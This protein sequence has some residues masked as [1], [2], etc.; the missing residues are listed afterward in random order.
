MQAGLN[1]LQGQPI[2][3]WQNY[4]ARIEAVTVADLAGFA[5]RRFARERCTQLVVR[6]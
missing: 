4:D 6:P 2:N 5:T 3:D 1:A